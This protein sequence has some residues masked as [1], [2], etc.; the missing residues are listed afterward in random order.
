M[1]TQPPLS[2]PTR[3]TDLKNDILKPRA[4]LLHARTTT[5]TN[6]ASLVPFV[7]RGSAVWFVPGIS[8]LP[9]YRALLVCI[10]DKLKGWWCGGITK[11]NKQSKRTQKWWYSLHGA[12]KGHGKECPWQLGVVS[13]S[14]EWEEGCSSRV[15]TRLKSSS[16]GIKSSIHHP[17]PKE[18]ES[19]IHKIL[20][21]SQF[22]L[23]ILTSQLFFKILNSIR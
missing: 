17:R 20:I 19:P 6:L 23:K 8:G 4:C 11:Y 16:R 22:F 7:N 18:I 21:A 12:E 5:P 14:V 10:P 15:V 13:Q 9:Y 3:A 1:V 2:W